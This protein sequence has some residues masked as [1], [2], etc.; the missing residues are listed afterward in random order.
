MKFNA[1]GNCWNTAAPVAAPPVP[2]D[3]RQVA[4]DILKIRSS[5]EFAGLPLKCRQSYEKLERALQQNKDGALLSEAS[6]APLMEWLRECGGA[7]TR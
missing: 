4:A 6:F 3:E 1:P 7:P 5:P 2:A